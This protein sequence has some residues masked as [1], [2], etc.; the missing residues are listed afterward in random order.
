MS[1]KAALL[2]CPV[3]SESV[4]DSSETLRDRLIFVSTNKILCPI[5]Q[6]EVIGIDKLTI[7]LFS[8]V[9]LLS[10]E[11][12]QPKDSK[13]TKLK[14]KYVNQSSVNPQNKK[15]RTSGV[16]NK[17][18]VTSHSPV[19]YVKIYPKLP[20]VSVNAVPLLRDMSSIDDRLNI[21]QSIYVPTVNSE[22]SILPSVSETTCNICGLQFVNA[23]ILKIHRC[24]IHNIDENANTKFTRYQCD[25]CPKH[26]KMRGSLMVHMRVA[27]Y[28]L[29]ANNVQEN[30]VDCTSISKQSN[31]KITIIDKNDNKQ[32]Q[33]DVCR[34][35]FT[36]KYFLKKHK[37]LH[38][39][40]LIQYFV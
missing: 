39:G 26:F 36:T 29:Q 9:K 22:A 2:P 38:T 35:C 32:W 27:H 37:R 16:K 6:E 33:C 21:T 11:N 13:E 3:C 23:N 28:G 5:C 12:E 10:T 30:N 1:A 14:S 20:I 7:H 15:L 4:F 24:L 18:N 34:K 31:D 40:L 25:I 8:H 19:K 17:A